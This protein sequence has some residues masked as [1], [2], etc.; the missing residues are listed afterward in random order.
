MQSKSPFLE[1]FANLMAGAAG[2]AKAAGDEARTAFRG[3]MDRFV[4]EMDLVGREE[5]DAMKQAALEARAECEALKDRI[6]ALEARLDAAATAAPAAK[7]PAKKAAK[8]SA[9]K[10]SAD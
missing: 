7:K 5:F 10:K 3:Q 8:T 4:A 1:D 9:A 2:A 6:A